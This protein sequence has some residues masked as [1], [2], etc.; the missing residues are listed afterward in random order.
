LLMSYIALGLEVILL[1]VF[2]S[3]WSSHMLATSQLSLII[4]L[5]KLMNF[6][7]ETLFDSD[8]SPFLGVEFMKLTLHLILLALYFPQTHGQVIIVLS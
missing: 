3:H 7:H 8:P 4:F 1:G 2:S 6:V 5:L